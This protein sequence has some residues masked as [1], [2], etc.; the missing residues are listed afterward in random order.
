MPRAPGTIS[1]PS[2]GRETTLIH[3][4]A[5]CRVRPGR[6]FFVVLLCVAAGSTVRGQVSTAAPHGG[7]K[8]VPGMIALTP[9]QCVW[10]PGDNPAWAAA[11][12]DESGWRPWSQWD[13]ASTAAHLWI[14]CHGDLSPLRTD[15]HP[16]LQ[17]TLY[18]AYEIYLDGR[19]IGSAGN[20]KTGGFTLNIVR[21][22]PLRANLGAAAVIALRVTR[23][24]VSTVPVGPAPRL[25]I[26][27]G[28]S[29]LLQ[30]RRSA[31]IVKQV[32]PRIFPVVCFCIVGVLA[33]V[34]LPL[35]LN[36]RERREL[37]LLSA[38]CGALP[39]I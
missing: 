39:F 15:A 26:E 31:T 10:R 25:A 28:D 14:R 18:A 11:A 32:A 36:D 27:A 22:W 29:E 13:P 7:G 6:A 34:L 19:A 5:R 35:W 33:F 23:R 38:S 21:A 12:L 4:T 17:V 24:V 20:L 9:Q 16:A 1:A 30:N 37:Q 8:P 2:P 3:A